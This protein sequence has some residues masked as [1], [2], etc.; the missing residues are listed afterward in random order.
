M[1]RAIPYDDSQR[2]NGDFLEQWFPGDDAGQLFKLEVWWKSVNFPLANI[3]YRHASLEKFTRTWPGGGTSLDIPRYRLTWLPRA[4]NAS[5]NDY[6]FLSALIDAVEEPNSPTYF[7]DVDS[8]IDYEQ[9][10]RVFAFE[11]AV[12]SGDSY[13]FGNGHNMYA[14]HHLNPEGGGLKWQLL[15]TDFDGVFQ[16]NGLGTNW[17]P[18]TIFTSSTLTDNAPT[19]SESGGH[20]QP[21]AIPPGLLALHLQPGQSHRRLHAERI[22]RSCLRWSL[23]GTGRK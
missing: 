6:S 2:P 12:L 7:S 21:S 8:R 20:V 22:G 14:Y 4:V 23:C 13:G 11:R 10:M 16:D 9:W 15:M 18:L 5:A 17:N 3:L 1:A 19:V